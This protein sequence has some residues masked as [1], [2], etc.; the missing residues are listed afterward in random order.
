MYNQ[1]KLK[2]GDTIRNYSKS[3]V[4]PV[5]RI[6]FAEFYDIEKPKIDAKF[7]KH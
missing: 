3:K 2:F 5:E 6:R 7:L 1:T 4:E